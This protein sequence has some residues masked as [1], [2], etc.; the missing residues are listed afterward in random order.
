MLVMLPEVGRFMSE[1]RSSP[2][3]MKTGLL[4]SLAFFEAELGYPSKNS[5]K[6]L[7][8]FRLKVLFL[9]EAVKTDAQ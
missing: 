4:K 3:L 7:L 2:N 8:R 9:L 5:T 6:L 1:I